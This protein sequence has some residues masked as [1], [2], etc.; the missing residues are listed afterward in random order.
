MR[1]SAGEQ[2]IAA[3]CRV[4][5]ILPE[6]WNT[7]E[8]IDIPFDKQHLRSIVDALAPSVDGAVRSLVFFTR[9]STPAYLSSVDLLLAPLQGQTPHN[10][11]SYSF[12]NDWPSGHRTFADFICRLIS[13]KVPDYA[14]VH[15]PTEDAERY[16][17][18]NRPMTGKEFA[19]RFAKPSVVPP[20]GPFGC[21]GDI[22]WFNF[23][24]PV[25]V[26][27]IGRDRLLNAGWARVDEVGGGCACYSTEQ[28]N[29]LGGTERR[30]QITQ[31]LWDFVWTPGC[32]ANEKRVPTF[33]FSEQLSAISPEIRAKLTQGQGAPIVTFAG[34]SDAEKSRAEKI[35]GRSTIPPKK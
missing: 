29:D 30:Q 12:N 6:F 21:L 9:K 33:D 24:G 32:T 18:L 25:Y 16:E 31:A 3:L 7:V 4:P 27:F 10:H 22:H 13:P 15:E 20:F 11:V 5:E 8:P 1:R 23:F 35:L 28:F 19:Q 2:I 26:D 34:L 17:E 14:I